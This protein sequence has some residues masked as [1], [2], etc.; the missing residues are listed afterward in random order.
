[1][2]ITY[3]AFIECVLRPYGHWEQKIGRI[4]VRARAADQYTPTGKD[5]ELALVDIKENRRYFQ[6]HNHN[7]VVRI[8]NNTVAFESEDAEEFS[9]SESTQIPKKPNMSN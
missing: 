7:A 4:D 5:A 6:F 1:M 8:V 9:V 2:S 3:I